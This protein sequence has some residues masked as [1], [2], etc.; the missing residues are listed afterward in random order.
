PACRRACNLEP[1]CACPSTPRLRR[2]IRHLEGMAVGSAH[3]AQKKWAS[4]SE[5]W[6]LDG[7][8]WTQPPNEEDAHGA[9]YRFGCS[10][11]K[12]GH[13]RD[14]PERKEDVVGSAGHVSELDHR[15][16]EEH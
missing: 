7:S 11:S 16:A 6:R 10:R 8:D 3:D 1:V 15:G 13:R 4:C 5:I 12:H 9:L 2:G 14:Q